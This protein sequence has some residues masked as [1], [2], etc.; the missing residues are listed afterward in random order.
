MAIAPT[1]FA[2]AVGRIR[3]LETKLLNANEVERM[4]GAKTPKDAYKILN[5]L[6]YSNHV[7][8]IDNLSGFQEVINAGLSDSKDILVKMSPAGWALDY[9]WYRYDFH[10]IK[11]LIKGKVA[12]KNIEQDVEPHLMNLGTIDLSI[13]KSIILEGA[14][15]NLKLKNSEHEIIIKE[16]IE[17]AFK[18]YEKEQNPQIIDIILDKAL[19][20]LL[21]K[22]A[23]KT[24]SKFL[25]D[26]TEISIDLANISTFLRAKAQE[27]TLDFLGEIMIEG[28]NIKVK[29]F[30]DLYKE[31]TDNIIQHFR[32]SN[33]AKIIQQGLSHFKSQESFIELEKLADDHK[34]NFIKQAKIIPFG[35]EPLIAFFWAKKNNAMIIRMIMIAKL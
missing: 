35:L 28:G 4:I 31:S 9:I 19:L 2:C 11:T 22:I 10:N 17:N 32:N 1:Q 12:N 27:K 18:H 33:Y 34:T 15:E 26:F 14:N 13:L 29:D 25:I 23:T 8:D 7:G 30:K 21:K 16:A 24:G 6:D 5:E 20:S 3:V